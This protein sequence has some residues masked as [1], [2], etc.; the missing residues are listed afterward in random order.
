[1]ASPEKFVSGLPDKEPRRE[2]TLE[3]IIKKNEPGI[4]KEAIRRRIRVPHEGAPVPKGVRGATNRMLG[5][6]DE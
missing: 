3:E 5:E 1:M 6:R 2:P 4:R